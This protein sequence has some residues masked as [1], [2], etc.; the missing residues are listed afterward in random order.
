MLE[1]LGVIFLSVLG[2]LLIV[3]LYALIRT[4]WENWS[5][6]AWKNYPKQPTNCKGFNSNCSCHQNT[7]ATKAERRA[8]NEREDSEGEAMIQRRLDSY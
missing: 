2:A 7:K 1:I 4:Y 8:V 3:F 6:K 5:R